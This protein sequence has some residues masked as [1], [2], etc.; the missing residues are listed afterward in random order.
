M[1]GGSLG[2][3]FRDV[4]LST[5][6]AVALTDL[7][8]GVTYRELNARVNALAAAL[9]AIGCRKQDRIAILA[10]NRFEYVELMLACAKLGLVAA[11]LNWRQTAEEM[12]Q[13]IGL[14]EPACLFVSPRYRSLAAEVTHNAE[15]IVLNE[16]YERLL[17]E[18]LQHHPDGCPEP[19]VEVDPED[20][21]LILYTSGTTG[22][23][24]GALISHRAMIARGAMMRADWS[25]RRSDGFIAWSPLFHM[26]SADPTLASMCQGSTVAVIDGFEPAQVADAL[27]R[28]D[29]GW[30]ILMPGMIERMAE[31]LEARQTHVKRVAAAGCMAN[32]VPPEQIARITAL[33]N[34]PFLNSFGSSETGIAPA[35]GNWIAPG[36]RPAS[37][38][39]LQTSCCEIKLV[40]EHDNE[41]APGEVGE[42]CLRTPLLFTGYW[43]NPDATASA[44]RGGWYHMG[45]DFYRNED[46]ALYFADRRKYLIKSGGE[47]IYPAEIEQVLRASEK[48]AEAIVVR[49]ADDHWGEVPVAFVVPA[50]DTLTEADVLA[51][52]DGKLARYKRPKQV[53]LITEDDLERNAT[54]KVRRELLEA[55][56]ASSPCT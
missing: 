22:R 29:V 2:G 54:G 33:L 50:V 17:A 12:A 1:I 49:R 7:S 15:V 36:E 32:L 34:A 21:L 27:S 52:L 3:M 38:G 8:N 16:H 23:S 46:G 43:N 13:S 25:I 6:N 40:D 24:K 39:K 28:I 41:V 19:A 47:N 4:A 44:M 10:E 35:S 51:L 11:C 18:Q 48:I 26:A 55:Q 30:F 53:F 37:L 5:P 56:A 9:Q 14:V 45:D 42:I 31:E 20:G